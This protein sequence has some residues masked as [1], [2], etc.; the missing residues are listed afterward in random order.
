V[1][2]DRRGRV[3]IDV[4]LGRGGPSCPDRHRPGSLPSSVRP[5][6]RGSRVWP[7]PPLNGG[8]AR[9]WIRAGPDPSPSGV[10]PRPEVARRPGDLASLNFRAVMVSSKIFQ[11]YAQMHNQIRIHFLMTMR[12]HPDAGSGRPSPPGSAAVTATGSTPRVGTPHAPRRQESRRGGP[13]ANR[14]FAPCRISARVNHLGSHFFHIFERWSPSRSL[15]IAPAAHRSRL[16]ASPL[17]PRGPDHPGIP[18]EPRGPGMPC[19][20]RSSE[21]SAVRTD[22]AGRGEPGPHVGHSKPAGAALTVGLRP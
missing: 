13:S 3:T 5:P 20:G 17:L 7:F 1:P 9:P 8:A 11:I 16:P 14:R 6:L 10:P 12:P 21:R 15:R 2:R 4:V 22:P 18:P 19:E